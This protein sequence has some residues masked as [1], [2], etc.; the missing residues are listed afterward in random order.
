MKSQSVVLLQSDPRIA[1]SLTSALS[2][3]FGSVERAK[4][5]AELRGFIAQ[6][7]TTIAIL[8]IEAAPLSEVGRLSQEFPQAGIVCTHRI[9][10]EDMWA[11]ALDAGAT[12]VCPSS[13]IRGIVRSA[14]GKATAAQAAAA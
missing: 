5:L 14:I 4:S 8:D 1:D 6:H 12:D 13:D 2:G 7:K 3:A 11:A 9:A 10:D